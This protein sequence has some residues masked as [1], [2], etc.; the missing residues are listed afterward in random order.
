MR[1]IFLLLVPAAALTL[2]L[3][4]PI[5]RLIY[6]RG[7]FDADSTEQVSTAL[8]WFSFSLPFSGVNLLLTRTFF[9]LQ[10]A[11]APTA[12]AA[13]NLVVNAAVS[14][15]LY[16]PLGI[17][18]LVIG[19]AVAS[20]GMTLGQAALL[21]RALGHIEARETTLAFATIAV[22]SAALGVAAYGIW[23][24]LDHALGRSLA[25]QLVSVGTATVVG[26]GLYA[27]LMLALRMP[28][29]E[30]IRRLVAGRLGRG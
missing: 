16:K 5:V 1:Q 22:A 21:R 11:W 26:G 15:A 7:S 20:L 14:L 6:Q 10:R 3:A 17:A 29:A 23:W 2:A 24:A 12:L 28:E 9:S 19:T 4:T 18:G 13:V 30:Q 25:G 8:F 27:G